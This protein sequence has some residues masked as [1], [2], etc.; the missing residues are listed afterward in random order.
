MKNRRS[1]ALA[2]VT[3]LLAIAFACGVSGRCRNQDMPADAASARSDESYRTGAY[4]FLYRMMDRYHEQFDVYSDKDAGGNHFVPSGWMGDTGDLEY[5]D[6]CTTEP[7]SGATCIRIKYTARGSHHAD[8]A[9][10]YWQSSER[11]WGDHPGYDLSGASSVTFWARGERGGER[12]EFKVGGINRGSYHDPNMPF[13]DSFGPVGTKPIK[14]TTSWQKY[15]INIESNK[16]DTVIGGFCIATNV[17]Q[18]P[19]GC[20]IYL[21]DISYDLPRLNEPHFIV[22]FDSRNEW[23][24]PYLRNVSFVYDN[25]LVLL[26]F[27]ARGLKS[28]MERAKLIA[29]AFIY[30]MDHDRR[31]HDGR[32]RNAYRSGDLSDLTG[33]SLLPGRWDEDSLKWFEDRVFVGTHTGNVAWASIALTQ[34]YNSHGGSEYLKASERLA[35]WVVDNCYSDK[36]YG[37]FTGGFEGWGRDSGDGTSGQT[38]LTWKST[39]H[40]ID[41][42]AVFMLLYKATG[43]EQYKTYGRHAR[44]FVERMWDD[45]IGLFRTGTSID[46]GGAGEIINTSALPL[47]VNPWALMALGDLDKYGRALNVCKQRFFVDSCPQGCHTSGYDFN[48][49]RDGIWYEGTAQMCVAYQIAGQREEAE[50]VL[51]ILRH[52][53]QYAKN[54]DG[55]GIVAA[56]HNGVS[57]GFHWVYNNRLHI[58]ATAWMLFAEMR[59]NP[60]WGIKTDEKIPYRDVP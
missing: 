14:L 24:D 60:Y 20:I 26:A 2:A 44:A 11:N 7:H 36:G 25:A 59:F 34:F 32:L 22:S 48:D 6:G 30:A 46:G 42:W 31:F 28:D 12:M 38:A 39:E 8:W 5:T 40:N 56:C 33:Q 3:Y 19:R 9:G 17:H 45:S 37:G 27:L 4:Q 21:D 57:T 58:G 43:N 15:S 16:L 47:D 49:D 1:T 41:L 23:F 13:Q 55:Q 35:Q 18:N 52:A 54:S 29:D 10:I 53:Q 51:L 50:S